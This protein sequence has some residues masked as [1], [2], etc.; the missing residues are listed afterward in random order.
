M[1]KFPAFVF[2]LLFAANLLPLQG[3]DD[4]DEVAFDGAHAEFTYTF[5]GDLE[6]WT[7][8][9][10][11]LPV[12]YDPSI[13]EL[14]SG[15][16]PLP[17]GLQ[18]GG[19]YVQG[20]NRS[21]DLFMYLKRQ[22][23]GLLPEATYT[24]SAVIDLATNVPAGSFGIG[25]SPGSSVFMK[26]GA[27]TVEPVAIEDANRHL[28]MNIDK[29]NQSRGG[30]SMAVLGDVAHPLVEN[31]EYRIKTLD[32]L[33]LPVSADTDDAGRLWLVVGTD[34]GFEGLTALYYAR[35]TYTL[36]LDQ[37]P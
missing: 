4:R 30:R 23:G 36:D 22:V 12:D 3:C 6:G 16:R 7:V 8:A 14:E 11:D 9:F 28:R 21:D 32:G 31:R 17:D 24:A 13:Y 29:G 33:D 27:F 25:G 2:G 18:G 19:I 15:H 5:D 26:A 1:K 34:S 20:H 37:L 35:M 10:A